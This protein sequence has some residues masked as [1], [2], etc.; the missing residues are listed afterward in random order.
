M[1]SKG[2]IPQTA[3]AVYRLLRRLGSLY[4]E[5]ARLIVAEKMTQLLSAG[6]MLIICL[7]LG[8]FALAFFSGTCVELLAM[9]LPAWAGY[10]ILGAFFVLLIVLIVV[11][12]KAL[13]VNPIARFISRLV[14]EKDHL[15]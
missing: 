4:A 11:F 6:L 3:Q 8:I 13:I 2:K 14:F 12:R 15:K 1:I 10:A 5:S 9:V 7:V